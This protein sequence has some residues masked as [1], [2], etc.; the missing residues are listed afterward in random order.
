VAGRKVVTVLNK[1]DLPAQ[2]SSEHLPERLDRPV[3][4]SAKQGTGISNLIHA[5]HRVC[6]VAGFPS[7][8]VVA[9]TDRQN[10]LLS[11]LQHAGSK[12]EAAS[13]IIELLEGPIPV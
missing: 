3:S 10:R 8:C 1:A 7:D 12:S 11:G 2:L 6:N 4:I 13:T 9:F 5:V